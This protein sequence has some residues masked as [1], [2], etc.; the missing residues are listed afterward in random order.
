MPRNR[1]DVQ[2]FW[3]ST[4]LC[5]SQ[6]DKVPWCHRL[7]CGVQA[8]SSDQEGPLEVMQVHQK[9]VKAKAAWG[10]TYCFH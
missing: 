5:M 2:R 9:M 1:T 7:V 6:Q 8:A 10:Q 4:L 3:P